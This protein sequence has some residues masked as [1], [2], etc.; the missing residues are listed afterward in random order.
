MSGCSDTSPKLLPKFRA[1]DTLAR[2]TRNHDPQAY[3]AW[4]AR[5]VPGGLAFGPAFDENHRPIIRL[6][7]P[8]EKLAALA[9]LDTLAPSTGQPRAMSADSIVAVRVRWDFAELYDWMQYLMNGLSETR[10]IGVNGAGIDT[11][12]DRIDF[13]VEK[14]ESV[15][16]LVSWLIEKGI[17]CRLVAIRVSGPTRLM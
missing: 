9:T 8:A 13:S 5:R 10:G 3:T 14:R 15:A 11:E 1:S 4:L 12:N 16:G 2:E 17:P 7:D 6:T